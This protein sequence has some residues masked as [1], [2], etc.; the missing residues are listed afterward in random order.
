MSEIL[1]LLCN[2]E[3]HKY[4]L[5]SFQIKYIPQMGFLFVITTDSFLKSSMSSSSINTTAYY[6]KLNEDSVLTGS[7]EE[8]VLAI[9]D[10]DNAPEAEE[11]EELAQNRMEFEFIYKMKFV[12]KAKG[13]FFYKNQ[14]MR[15]LDQEFGDISSDIN[16]LEADIMDQ[17]QD[18][19]VKFSHYYANMLDL[20]SELDTLMAFASIAKEHNYVK[21]QYGSRE[22]NS[23]FVLVQVRKGMK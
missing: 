12:F 14:R 1:T 7:E 17:V 8:E 23:S 13:E 11:S 19:F 6:S 4:D 21:P 20:C 18:E 3:Q 22:E 10:Q 15:E 9:N 16:D 5:E 2:E